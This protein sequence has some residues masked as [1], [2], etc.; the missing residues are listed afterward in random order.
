MIM[1]CAAAADG[2]WKMLEAGGMQQER[3]GLLDGR[4]SAFYR[5]MLDKALMSALSVIGAVRFTIVRE[6][7]RGAIWVYATT[8]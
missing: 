1:N 8:Q 7:G 4:G 5:Q 2:R 3:Q 6:N